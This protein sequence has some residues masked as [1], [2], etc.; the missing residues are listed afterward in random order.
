MLYTSK[1]LYTCTLEIM[2]IFHAPS[3]LLPHSQHLTIVIVPP[4]MNLFRLYVLVS[5]H[6][7]LDMF[8]IFSLSIISFMPI[9]AI[10]H[11]RVTILQRQRQ[12][13]LLILSSL[14]KIWVDNS[15]L[16]LLE[17][18][19]HGNGIQ[20]LHALTSFP[21]D[22]KRKQNNQTMCLF[23]FQVLEELTLYIF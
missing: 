11:D 22:N 1:P 5:L 15:M 3:L 14:M 6:S 7:Y 2:C 18:C 17:H 16:T 4:Q 12:A 23:Y 13:L 8:G 21:L 20:V 10:T 9:Y 19:L